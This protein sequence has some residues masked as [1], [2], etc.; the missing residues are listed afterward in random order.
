MHTTSWLIRFLSRTSQSF[1]YE[2]VLGD[3][4]SLCSLFSPCRLS[5]SNALLNKKSARALNPRS[6]SLIAAQSF[7]PVASVCF[8]YLH[9]AFVHRTLIALLPTPCFLSLRL[10]FYDYVYRSRCST[11][12]HAVKQKNSDQYIQCTVCILHRKSSPEIEHTSWNYTCCTHALRRL[13]SGRN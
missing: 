13:C 9:V 3:A 10:C 11:T 6:R 4:S 12:H 7:S 5:H 1:C 2:P 8:P